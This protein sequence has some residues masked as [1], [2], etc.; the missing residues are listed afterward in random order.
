MEQDLLTVRSYA[1]KNGFSTQW[2]RKLIKANKIKGK[3]IDGVQFV[4]PEKK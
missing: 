1:E 2:V 3:V 4:I